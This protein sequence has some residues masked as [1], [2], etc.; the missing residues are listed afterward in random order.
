VNTGSLR[1][2]AGHSPALGASPSD[3]PEIGAGED[4]G[5]GPRA[6]RGLWLGFLVR[7]CYRLIVSLF[8]VLT[9]TFAMIHLIPGDPVRAAL[10]PTASPELVASRRHLLGLDQPLLHQYLHYISGL[11]T[12]NFGTSIVTNQPVGDLISARLPNTLEL[13]GISFAVVVL[14]AYPLG[15]LLAVRTYGDRRQRTE[16]VFTTA[17][18]VIGTIPEFV[19]AAGLVA[20]FSVAIRAFPVAGQS[21]V[22][23]YVLPVTALSAGPAAILARV[24]RVEAVRV[25]GED[26]MR[27]ARGKRLT[28]RA[29]YLRHAFPNMVTG[30]LTIAGNLLPALIAGTVLVENVFAWPGLGTAIADSVIQEDYAVVQ[31]VVLVLATTVLLVNFAIDVTL[32]LLDPLSTVRES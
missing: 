14:I 11:F 23:S 3:E 16:L 26:Y 7:R 31:A 30:S 6:G 20:A 10:G 17:T 25:L 8:V 24:V 21:G 9:A 27:T 1:F 2:G 28:R 12:G 13:A 15:L 29:L 4:P 22:L 18:S 5:R 32:A 19:L